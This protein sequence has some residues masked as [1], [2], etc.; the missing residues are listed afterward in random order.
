MSVNIFYLLKTIEAKS[1]QN[2]SAA[3]RQS[4]IVNSNANDFCHIF[5]FIPIFLKWM[6]ADESIM[7]LI[8]W[9]SMGTPFVLV[10]SSQK[11]HIRIHSKSFALT[12]LISR[13]LFVQ[14]SATRFSNHFQSS[15]FDN[16]LHDVA[17]RKKTYNPFIRRPFLLENHQ[18]NCALLFIVHQKLY[19]L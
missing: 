5:W 14:S 4:S 15:F 11:G 12:F 8:S 9:N 16:Y 2:Y 10:N 6:F 1:R 3:G 19:L 18:Q 7:P 17:K 13:N